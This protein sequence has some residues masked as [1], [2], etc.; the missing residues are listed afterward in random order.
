VLR[1]LGY[2]YGAVF[3]L[4]VS[5]FCSAGYLIVK[6]EPSEGESK[7]EM[8]PRV[9]PVAPDNP[10]AAKLYQ[11]MLHYEWPTAL[12]FPAAPRTEEPEEVQLAKAT[13]AAKLSEHGA[14]AD[15]Q[16]LWVPDTIHE[17]FILNDLMEGGH[18]AHF[19]SGGP[20]Y[21][22]S[23][24]T[25]IDSEAPG[26]DA[27]IRHGIEH[28]IEDHAAVD[29][30]LIKG[31]L[32][33]EKARFI[34][35]L[36]A[37]NARTQDDFFTENARLLTEVVRHCRTRHANPDLACL[38]GFLRSPTGLQALRRE[39]AIRFNGQY[40]A[41]R[42]PTYRLVDKHK[43]ARKMGFPLDHAEEGPDPGSMIDRV[44]ELELEAHKAGDALLYRGSN[45][46]LDFV[47]SALDRRT[48]TGR[49]PNGSLAFGASLFGGYFLDS[50]GSVA[51]LPD[52]SSACAMHYMGHSRYAYV[53]RFPKQLGLR[54]EGF[55]HTLFL[56]PNLGILGR[57]FGHGEYFHPRTRVGIKDNRPKKRVSG[58]LAGPVSAHL[59]IGLVFDKNLT[60]LGMAHDVDE[61]IAN[62]MQL[63]AI[64]HRPVLPGN[65]EAATLLEHQKQQAHDELSGTER[66][67]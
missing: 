44:V 22:K 37:I 38:Q 67:Q 55:L 2:A 43:T 18:L 5:S 50:L 3:T 66:K 14:T 6:V 57:L 25:P 63:L 35:T 47:D 62:H 4:L 23:L 34:E 52:E 15:Y 53:L 24:F 12:G 21:L 46:F 61:F 16:F 59:A 28:P 42:F 56:I 8:K 45:G 49:F 17:L 64:D 36:N 19:P 31:R 41:S 60:P 33:V 29:Y 26:Y 10:N 30:W 1:T 13:E 48:G 27:M 54:P 32:P 65:S 40:R 9:M 7:L 20:Y 39:L 11:L 58:L 51:G